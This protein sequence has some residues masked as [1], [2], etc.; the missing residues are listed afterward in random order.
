MDCAA[1]PAPAPTGALITALEV[2]GGAGFHGQLYVATRWTGG[3]GLARVD[4]D[5]T[6]SAVPLPQVDSGIVEISALATFDGYLLCAAVASRGCEAGTVLQLFASNLSEPLRWRPVCAPDFGAEGGGA[7]ISA[8]AALEDGCY[9]CVD[10]PGRGFQVWRAS[11]ADVA[12]PWQ[13]E[14]VLF[15]GAQRF[16][17]NERVNAHA[18]FAGA[19]YLGTALSAAP[20][21]GSQGAGLP[22]CELVRIWPGNEWDIVVGGPRFSAAGL[23]V[24]FAS[25]GPGFGRSGNAALVG[26]CAASGKLFAATGRPGQLWVSA[27]G[28]KWRACNCND[29]TGEEFQQLIAVDEAL[30]IATGSADNTESRLWLV[31]AI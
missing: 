27:D 1:A 20:G 15:D 7:R 13:W 21:D 23:K 30:L 17:L 11:A 5:G 24:P 18:V 4:R 3:V 22:G 31:E 10:H 14:P 9:A 19:L 29:V 16:S 8:V 26:L 28:D 2:P 25:L 6:H 12:G